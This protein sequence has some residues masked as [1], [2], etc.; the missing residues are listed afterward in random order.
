[1]ARPGLTIA[2]LVYAAAVLLSAIRAVGYA[3]GDWLLVV[4][5]LTLPWSLISLAFIWSLVHGASLWFFWLVY[6][7]GGAV[8]AFLVYRYAPKLYARLRRRQA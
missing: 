4:I 5:A 6:L 2:V 7:A 3:D 8:N 1:M